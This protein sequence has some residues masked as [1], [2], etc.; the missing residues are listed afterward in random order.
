MNE[1]E[2]VRELMKFRGLTQAELSKKAGYSYQSA[3]SSILCRQSIRTDTLVQLAEAM[4]CEVVV[5]AKDDSHEWV[6]RY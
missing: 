6:I 3:I 4:E 5:R 1:K 2:I